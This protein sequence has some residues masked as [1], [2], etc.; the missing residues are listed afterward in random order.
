MSKECVKCS[1]QFPI[2]HCLQIASFVQ[3]TAQNTKSLI[4][5]VK[6]SH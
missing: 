1:A 2:A 5:S 6:S 4:K 3:T